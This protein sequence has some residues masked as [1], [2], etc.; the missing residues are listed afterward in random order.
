[1]PRCQKR[2]ISSSKKDDLRHDERAY[3]IFGGNDFIQIQRPPTRMIAATI[4]DA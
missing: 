1:M 3:D 2:G 4:V